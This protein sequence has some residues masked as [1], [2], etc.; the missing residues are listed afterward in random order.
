MILGKKNNVPKAFIHGKEVEIVDTYKYL[1]TVFDSKLKFDANTDSIVKRGQQRIHLL[2][3]LK[4][5]NVCNKIVCMFYQSFIESLLTFSF[6]C[7]FDGLCVKDRNSLNSIVKVCS[8]IIGVRQRDL[9]SIWEKRVVQKAKRIIDQHDHV[10]SSEFTLMHSGRHFIAPLR[11]TNR[12]SKSF[13]PSAIRLLN[14][15]NSLWE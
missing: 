1:G 9:C 2:R 11:K 4:S 15:D 6:I 14:L 8:K 5:F 10:L 12:Y 3:K 7:W 13:I